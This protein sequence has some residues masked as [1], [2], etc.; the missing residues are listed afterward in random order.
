MLVLVLNLLVVAVA[1]VAAEQIA[2]FPPPNSVDDYIRVDISNGGSPITEVTIA[3]WIK[4]ATPTASDGLDG[5][6]FSYM[7]S[8]SS[9]DN[10]LLLGGTESYCIKLLVSGE[11]QLSSSCSTYGITVGTSKK[12]L[13]LLYYSPY[14]YSLLFFTF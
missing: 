14:P 10:L 13:K 9:N 8:P 3:A 12:Y 1:A 2:Y 4:H 7:S 6:F 5:Y 11:S